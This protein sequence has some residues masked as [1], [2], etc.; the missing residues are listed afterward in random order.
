MIIELSE[1]YIPEEILF[2]DSQMNQIKDVFVNYKRM[3]IGTN[4]LILGVTGSGKTT[5]IKKIIEE[6]DN[7]TYISCSNKKT[8]HEV[9]KS[10]CN[11]KIRNQSEVLEKTIK[12][13]KTN[14]KIIIID[15]IDKIKD[16]NNFMNDINTIYR[17]TM[18]PIIIITLKRNILQ[19]IPIDAKKTLF[20]EKVS[21]P[22][23]NAYE[24]KE[25]LNYR[26]KLINNINIKIPDGSINF[27]SAIAS[28][29]GSARVLINILI[30]C[31]QKNNFTQPFIKKIYDD[32][33]RQDWISFID[34]INESEKEF[35]GYILDLCDYKKETTSEQIQTVMK[36]SSARTSQLINTFEKYGAII[37]RHENKGRAGGRSRIIKFSSQEIY[38]DLSNVLEV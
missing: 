20:F 28:K 25:I 17:K 4:L 13:L 35:L 7:S 6:E 10:I 31:I 14:P 21:L 24:L 23:Y 1:E 15:E 3:G 29:H 19:N 18:V 32:L 36:I 22:S 37:S 5:I 2:R 34:E 11:I 26:I 30:R 33:I 16:L 38:D 8:T 27:I 12:E 9:L